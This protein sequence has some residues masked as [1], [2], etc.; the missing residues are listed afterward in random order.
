MKEQRVRRKEEKLNSL[1]KLLHLCCVCLYCLTLGKFEQLSIS[2]KHPPHA[3][4]CTVEA[5]HRSTLSHANAVTS[6]V[7]V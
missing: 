3:Y 1:K 6:T 5:K 4:D 7:D 2:T